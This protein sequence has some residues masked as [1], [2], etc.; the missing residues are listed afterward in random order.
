MGNYNCKECIDK[1]YSV[2]NEM[3]LNTSSYNKETNQENLRNTRSERIKVLKTNNSDKEIINLEE[4]NQSSKVSSQSPITKTKKQKNFSHNIL[5]KE[6]KDNN[7]LLKNELNKIKEMNNVSKNLNQKKLT[8]NKNQDDFNKIIES[9]RKQIIAQEKIIAEYKNK[10]SLL[11]EQKKILEQTQKKIQEQQFLLN[12]QYIE[13][14]KTYMVHPPFPYEGENNFKYGGA[15]EIKTSQTDMMNSNSKQKIVVSK[16]TPK[17]KIKTGKKNFNQNYNNNINNINMNIPDIKKFERTQVIKPNFINF[18][19][20]M[21][22][23]ENEHPEKWEE[24]KENQIEE[25]DN[26]ERVDDNDL[27]EENKILRYSHPQSKRFKIETYE[28]IEPGNKNENDEVINNINNLF[29]NK[30]I[31]LEPRDSTKLSLRKAVI[32]KSNLPEKNINKE[33]YSKKKK[34]E[35]GPKDNNQAQTGININFRGTFENENI[36]KKSIKKND[37][38]HIMN[39][40]Q[41]GPRDSRRKEEIVFSYNLKK[42]NNKKNNNNSNNTPFILSNEDIIRQNFNNNINDND[43]EEINEVLIQQQEQFNNENLFQ[44]NNIYFSNDYNINNNQQESPKFNSKYNEDINTTDKNTENYGPYLTQF[45]DINTAMPT[46][47]FI[48][49]DNDPEKQFSQTLNDVYRPNLNNIDNGLNN[50]G[51][52]ENNDINNNNI[53]NPLMYS[54]DKINT[55]F[56]ENKNEFY[57]E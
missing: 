50:L 13:N 34:K 37:I 26:Y 21:K 16:S 40:N 9:Q 3:L 42:E 38:E 20:I 35:S 43:N 23:K 41:L 24:N 7:I 5:R 25:N 30:D 57:Q 11:E 15:P 33:R 12:E 29:E 6:E 47:P 52:I 46:I 17:L 19:K 31:I 10:Q 8:N 55:N 53:E 44:N 18:N 32:P 49:N 56:Y 22:E 1:D 28:P 27:E 14:K 39:F 2:M 51:I 45:N 54:V 36:N 4:N 48:Y